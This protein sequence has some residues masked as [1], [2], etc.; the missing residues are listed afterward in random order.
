ME[1]ISRPSTRNSS[2][3]N[4]IKEIVIDDEHE[5]VIDIIKLTEKRTRSP[6]IRPLKKIKVIEEDDLK[7]DSDDV[8]APIP[9]QQGVLSGGD[10]FALMSNQRGSGAFGSA[11]TDLRK[12]FKEQTLRIRKDAKLCHQQAFSDDQTNFGEQMYGLIIN[13]SSGS[14]HFN[15]FDRSCLILFNYFDRSNNRARLSGLYAP[16]VEIMEKGGFDEV[17]GVAVK[18][19]RWLLVN[20]HKYDEFVCQLFMREC[21]KHE[22]VK[23]I[24]A[25]NFVFWHV[26]YDS[27]EGLRYCTHYK[28]EKYPHLAIIDPRTGEKV[29]AYSEMK[30]IDFC[31]VITTF[32]AERPSYDPKALQKVASTSGTSHPKPERQS[33]ESSHSSSIQ[34]ID[35]DEEELQRVIELSRKEE[36]DRKRRAGE[37]IDIDDIL[38]DDDDDEDS[39]EAEGGK[40]ESKIKEQKK[41]RE[42]QQIKKEIKEEETEEKPLSED[43]WKEFLGNVDDPPFVLKIRLPTGAALDLTLPNSSQL[44]AV[45]F[46]LAGRGFGMDKYE[47]KTYF[48]KRNLSLLP[49]TTLLRDAD[50]SNREVLIVSEME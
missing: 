41:I 23:E 11:F 7:A 12:Q 15:H 18:K 8:R 22:A 30:A 40:Y 37:I 10:P 35:P 45:F 44:Q 34:L 1:P 31:N 19:A 14:V 16:P 20:I 26:D 24:I 43:A 39:Q 32:L 47:T 27:K 29:E 38:Y 2:R 4:K 21:I 48:Q 28:V 42:V 49:P 13:L 5:E 17:R 6:R 9:Q 33:S 50:L 3:T 25:E 36:E 46:F